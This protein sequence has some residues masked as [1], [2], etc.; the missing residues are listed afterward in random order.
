MKR[1]SNNEYR[2]PSLYPQR[3]NTNSVR[4]YVD[5]KDQKLTDVVYNVEQVA[6]Q[7]LADDAGALAA[8]RVGGIAAKAVMAD[9]IRQ[10]NEGLGQLAWVIMNLSDR[11]DVRQWSTLPQTIQMKKLWLPAGKHKIRLQGLDYAGVPTADQFPEQEIEV[12]PRST[13]FLHWRTLR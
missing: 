5:E 3:S 12:K 10:K 13:S 8:R 4:V 1:M 11:A 2:I 6:I 7:T 9:Q